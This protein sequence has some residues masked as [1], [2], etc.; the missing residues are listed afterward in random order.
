MRNVYKKL[1]MAA[2]LMV[3]MPIAA[4]AAPVDQQQAQAKASAFLLTRQGARMAPSAAAAPL[5]LLHAEPSTVNA[6]AT[7]YFVFKDGGDNGF[8]IVSG[9]DRACG[10]LAY[11]D[12]RL[13][14]NDL[15]C[16]LQCLLGHYKE[17]MEW[18]L[19]HPTA[20]V[21]AEPLHAPAVVV[22]PLLTCTWSQS[23]P[24]NDLCPEYRHEHC[25][26]GCIAT[27]MAQVM[28]YWQYPEVL[29]DY[30][31]YVT[32]AIDVPALP[33]T[34]LNWDDMLDS[35]YMLDGSYKM[36]YSEAQGQSVATLMRYCGQATKMGYGVDESGALSWNQMTAMCDFG[37]YNGILEK[38][39]DN[40][41]AEDWIA[42][43]LQE[44]TANRPILY[45]GRGDIGGHAF[46]VDG[47]DG[48]KF[49][50]NWGWEGSANAY[51]ALDAFTAYGYYDFSFN[52]SMLIN[53]FPTEES[54]PY[55][56]E[57]D[58]IAYRRHGNELTVTRR[59]KFDNTYSGNVTIP[60]HVTVDGQD[61]VVTAIGN[62]AFKNCKQLRAVTLPETL[63]RI[64]KYAFK[65]CKMLT[66]MT[67][68]EGVESIDWAA[69]QDCNAIRTFTFNP[70]VKN[71][72]GY[73]FTYCGGLKNLDL[74]NSVK[75]IDPDAFF[76]CSGLKN[77]SIDMECVPDEAFYYCT[78][79]NTVNLGNH[80]KTIG[81]GA[82]SECWSLATVNM[83]ANVD[84]IAPMAFS[85]CTAIKTIKKLPDIP[86]LVADEN[87]FPENVYHQATLY[88]PEC[89]WVDY[90]CCDVWTLF[91]HQVVE[92]AV[93][94]GD[95]NLDGAVNIA[96]VNL[97]IN[98]ILSGASTTACDVNGDG[99]VNIADVNFIINRIL[100][101]P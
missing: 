73:A 52:Q 50:I 25:L 46:V 19:D 9:D 41:T 16:G 63:K 54:K 53:V 101:T 82:F 58:G 85:G 15:P 99:S 2:L 1:L 30:P 80:V 87:C 39:R 79:L 28:Y 57:V 66:A 4:M 69:F 81:E 12:S 23:T 95:A 96:D 64:E 24:Y 56:V 21:A 14:M 84:S 55:D 35:Y 65:G 31:A 10:I 33:A 88:V 76:V 7:D 27:A 71:I 22:E 97:V 78:G 18:L 67:L 11:G 68:P 70:G 17:Q 8:V 92:P 62:S 36:L 93:L 45:S 72:E 38:R 59:A 86:P 77:L 74:P 51:F 5:S 98:D 61:W 60:S 91:D 100:S 26:T 75:R 90:Y 89:A 43:M 29:P 6:L 49:H 20:A 47:Y 3:M 34:T 94:P 32:G 83:G 40:Y 13:D 44:L 48:S 42:L 37:Y